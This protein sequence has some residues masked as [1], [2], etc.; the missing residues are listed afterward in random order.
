MKIAFFVHD[1]HRHGGHSRYVAE[2]ASRLKLNHEVHVFAN[3]WEEPNPEGIIF[4][5]VPAISNRELLKVLSFIVPATWMAPKGFDIIHAQGL[6]G[7]RHDLTT[8][9]FIQPLWLRELKSRGYKPSKFS[10]LWTLVVPPLEHFALGPNCSK[11]VIAISKRIVDDLKSEYNIEKNVDLIYHGTDIVR[12]HPSL[13]GI[14]RDSIRRDWKVC[15]SDFIALF[16]GN[17]QKGA[18]A[19][20]KA[21]NSVQ[22]ARLALV[23]GSNNSKEKELCRE[24][25][26][27]DRIIWI[28]K[29]KEVEKYFAAADCFVFPTVYEP[30]GMV[31]SEA[32]ASGLPVI[33]SKSAGA[34]DLIKHGENGFL[35]DEPW[36]W[37]SIGQHIQFLMHDPKKSENIGHLARLSVEPYTWD[38]CATET[39]ACY[40]K[41]IDGRKA[42]T[43]TRQ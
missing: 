14:Y 1:Y 30:F 43:V 35:V 5:K 39:L 25:G 10:W 7:L 20:I 24:L 2:L 38:K 22:G 17:L 4:H 32:M 41:I 34:A 42:P 3:T 36:D 27:E 6:C 33:T 11:R 37:E 13:K 18:H 9:H 16:V 23:S 31:I 21:V 8:A 12:F 15:Q 40:Q 26:V 28:P 29:S 19:A